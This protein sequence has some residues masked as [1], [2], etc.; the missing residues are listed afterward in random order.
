MTAKPRQGESP[1][2][3]TARE[4]WP[5]LKCL[6]QEWNEASRGERWKKNQNCRM[7]RAPWPDGT[8]SG[9]LIVIR[10]TPAAPEPLGAPGNS[11]V[12]G[13]NS[14]LVVRG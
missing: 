2:K 5:H 8:V 9:V 13:N 12:F 10:G 1:N 3:H 11:R 6:R 7:T 14:P 4:E